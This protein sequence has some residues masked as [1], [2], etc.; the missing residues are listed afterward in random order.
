MTT[1]GG[2]VRFNPNLYDTGYVCLTVLNAKGSGGQT[3]RPGDSNIL[4][5]ILAI[6]YF[7]LNKVS[8]IVSIV[9]VFAGRLDYAFSSHSFSSTIHST[10]HPDVPA[11]Q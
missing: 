10:I 8:N 5:V 7:C 11:L 6:E 9:H 3:W 4:E 2:T 1:G